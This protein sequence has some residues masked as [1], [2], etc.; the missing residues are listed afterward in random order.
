M[1]VVYQARELAINRLVALKML[2]HG[3]FSDAAF[4]ERFHLEAEAAAHLDHPNIV[5]IYEVGQHDGQPFYSMK[6]IEGQSLERELSRGPMPPKKA[7]QLIATVARAVAFAHHRGVLHRDIK[8]HN[9]LLDAAGQPHLTDF[10]LAKLLDQ[11]SGLTVSTDIIGSPGF[12]APEQAAGKTRQVTT[13]ADVYGLGA[14]LYALLTG[15]AVFQADTPL[16]TV[17]LVIEQEPVK[18][19]VCNPS[20]DRDLETICLKCLQKEPAKR[21]ASAQALAEDLECWLRAE[22]IQARPVSTTERAWLWCRRQPVRA[23]LIGALALSLALGLSGVLWQWRR[24]T[25]G[26]LQA[27]QIAYAAEMNLAQ[28]AV[29]A[30]NFDFAE[31]LL[32]KYR[33]E[34]KSETR[35]PKSEVGPA[36]RH[37]PLVPRP[38]TPATDF[39]GWEWRYL[40]QLCQADE[41]TKLQANA[42]SIGAVAISQDGRVLAAQTGEDKIRLWDLISKRMVNELPISHGIDRLRLS[43][44]GNL[45]AVTTG[46]AQGE[47][48]VEIWDLPARAMRRTLSY[49]SPVRSLAFSPD[50]RLLATMEDQGGIRLV[51]W[52]ANHTLTSFPVSPASRRA[53]AGV[54]EFTS[55]G[56]RLVIGEAYGLIRILNWQTNSV[57]TI[58]NLTQTGDGVMALACSPNSD[59]FAA[60]FGYVSGGIYLGDT[61]SG[62]P[63]GQLIGHRGEVWGLAF[64]PDGQR[65]ASAGA[66][67]TIR[68]WSVGDQAELKSLRRHK[69]EGKVLAFL[70]D[71][72]T[73]ASGCQASVACLWDLITT[74]S[75]ITH[76][77]LT[78]SYGAGSRAAVEP[79]GYAPGSL[80]QKTVRRF[81]FAFTPDGRQ[82]ITTDQEGTLGVW[83]AH[84]LE[85]TGTL[86]A[87]GSNHWGV[88]LSPD[89]RWL[90]A[91]ITSE[92]VNL[93]DWQARRL[94]QTLAIPFEWFGRLFFS[95]SGH[96]LLG[97]TVR[98][99]RTASVRIWRTN[100][101]A[102]VPWVG[103]QSSN[104]YTMDLSPDDRLL[105]TGDAN[106]VVRLG[107]FLS[108]EPGT[109]I[110]NHR[111]AV[112]ALAF[113]PDGRVLASASM[114][115]DVRL[116][117]VV[118]GREL[119]TL[120]GHLGA[121]SAAFSPDGRR[122]A[123]G[124]LVAKDAV[125]LWDLATQRE[126]LTLTPQEACD[127]FFQIACSPDGSTLAAT[128]FTG[129]THLWRAPSWDEIAATERRAAPQPGGGAT[130]NKQQEL[131]NPESESPGAPPPGPK[132]VSNSKSKS[133]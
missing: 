47:P 9:I 25:A 3:R 99:D 131:R 88:A 5:P 13:A 71:R 40:W 101:W 72:R 127:S 27:R 108:G 22:P 92:K 113:S 23:S 64:T 36:T 84:S 120:R 1:G 21:Y 11:E 93:W 60:G 65:L 57:V 16:E 70:P 87:W 91:G 74:R 44:N 24:A 68:V 28:H 49:S 118:A 34:G 100:D 45:L 2:L 103:T 55:D 107:P 8:P 39:R 94:V 35:N 42:R 46:P 116:W 69:G 117:N 26:E 67:R 30:N 15:K 85:K 90:A 4:V 122:L 17:R 66:D 14:V 58:T 78:N 121:Y 61:R 43:S 86:S 115:G 105:A 132:R 82:F 41:S 110:L 124:G 38:S 63:R 119:P 48:T 98:T 7:A 73:L 97:G 31:S 95:R 125:K 102:I 32:D 111:G 89:G 80:D 133:P 18:P 52:A 106:G 75:P 126:I 114:D 79:P 83:D 29:A 62:E 128:S 104:L 51:E 54:V 76:S 59:L 33:P 96:F 129:V 130:A 6:L 112:T 12:M 37:S 56:S 20:V 77:T 53:G 123:T 10:G 50:G 109:T 19:R 81:G